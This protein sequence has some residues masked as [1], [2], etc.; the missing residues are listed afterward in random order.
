[1][2][3][4]YRS[5]AAEVGQ[6]FV[7]SIRS[8]GFRSTHEGK[9]L[10]EVI[11]E[12]IVGGIRERTIDRQQR[13]DGSP[14][15]PNSPATR[16]RKELR[17]QEP[18]TNVDTGD[19][20]SIRAL[21]GTTTITDDLVRMEYGTGEAPEPVPDRLPARHRIDVLGGTAREPVTD[22]E[23]ALWAYEQ[24]RDFYGLDQK[25]ADDNFADFSEALGAQWQPS[26]DHRSS[27]SQ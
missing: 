19:M 23:K 5:N 8:F 20:L 6:D 15:P 17:G 12:N 9:A 27:A 21:R 2:S 4:T 16:R 14:L 22:V 26:T 3:H 18:L 10:G 7:D 13:V 11:V 24:G 25:I 1:M